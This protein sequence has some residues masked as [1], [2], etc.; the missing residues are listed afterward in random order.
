MTSLALC[1]SSAQQPLL[2]LHVSSYRITSLPFSWP[3]QPYSSKVPWPALTP[4]ISPAS[5][6]VSRAAVLLIWP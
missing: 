4:L 6:V 3:S 2:S 5:C 1:L